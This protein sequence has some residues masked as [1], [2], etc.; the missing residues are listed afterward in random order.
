MQSDGNHKHRNECDEAT[1]CEVAE[2][3]R[4]DRQHAP[5]TQHGRTQSFGQAERRRRAAKI[6]SRFA[7]A[8]YQD[9][10]TKQGDGAGEQ[11]A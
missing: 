4:N 9:D 8:R 11:R 7:A 2:Q 3:N 6:K 10:A 1:L 5:G